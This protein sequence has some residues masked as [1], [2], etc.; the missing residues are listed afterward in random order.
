[1]SLSDPVGDSVRLTDLRPYTLYHLSV[2]ARSD[3]FSTS[4][5]AQQQQHVVV[6]NLNFSTA[7]EKGEQKLA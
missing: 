5:H 7:G 3:T 2:R 1:M 4:G 6:A